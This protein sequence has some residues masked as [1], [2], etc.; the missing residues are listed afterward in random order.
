MHA[1]QRER[2]VLG[3]HFKSVQGV[4]F[5]CIVFHFQMLSLTHQKDLVPSWLAVN[6]GDLQGGPLFLSRTFA[7]VV[8][9]VTVVSCEQCAAA[10]GMPF[11]WSVSSAFEF[12]SGEGTLL[13]PGVLTQLAVLVH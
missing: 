10:H 12:C 13:T 2:F 7:S 4:G 6:S 1:L 11:T 5:R 3:F 8:I 9:T